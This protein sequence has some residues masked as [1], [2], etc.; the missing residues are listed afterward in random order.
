LPLFWAD[1]DTVCQK[2][3]FTVDPSYSQSGQTKVSATL[4]KV[5]YRLY[6]YFDYNWWNSLTQEEAKNMEDIMISLSN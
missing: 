1:A 4:R 3:D 5:S 2:V 6:F